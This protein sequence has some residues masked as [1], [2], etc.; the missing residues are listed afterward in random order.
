M[1]LLD[2]IGNIADKALSIVPGYTTVKRTVQGFCEEG[3]AGA[4]KGLAKGFSEDWGITAL[5]IIGTVIPGPWTPI[6]VGVGLAQAAGTVVGLTGA[7]DLK[8]EKQAQDYSAEQHEQLPAG[9]PASAF[10]GNEPAP[11][12]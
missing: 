3:L 2:T 7:L 4:C 6:C 8:S 11:G 12:W 10:W 1:G 9:R 5:S